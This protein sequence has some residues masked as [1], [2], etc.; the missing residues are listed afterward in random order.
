MI[1]PDGMQTSILQ[2]LDG[3]KQHLDSS[4]NRVNVGNFNSDGLNVNNWDDDN[5]NDNLGLAAGRNFPLYLKTKC[6]LWSRKE[7]FV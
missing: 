7:C 2:G 6:S 4:G 5:R 1:K 3:N